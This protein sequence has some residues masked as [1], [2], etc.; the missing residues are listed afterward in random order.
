MLIKGDIVL[1]NISPSLLTNLEVYQN[2]KELKINTNFVFIFNNKYLKINCFGAIYYLEIYTTED[3]PFVYHIREANTSEIP[4]HR[5][6]SEV[7]DKLELG[8][9]YKRIVIEP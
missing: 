9:E 1:T 6:F 8:D 4:T 3:S 2:R 5:E 7:K